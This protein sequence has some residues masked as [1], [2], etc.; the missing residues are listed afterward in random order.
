MSKIDLSELEAYIKDYANNVARNVAGQIRDDLF[1]EAKLAIEAF[2]NSY[3]PKYYRRH[4]YNFY[5]KSFKKYYSNAHCTIYRGGVELTPELM[6]DIYQD[7]VQ[8][9]FD[10]V[11]IAGLHGPAGAITFGYDQI[12]EEPKFFTPVRSN[13]GTV[14]PYKRIMDKRDYIIDHIQDY[15]DAAV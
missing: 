6:D 10:T 11:F 15:I 12:S 3:S 1:D 14:S 2:Y 4:Y 9:V 7:P 13:A 5:N 8:E